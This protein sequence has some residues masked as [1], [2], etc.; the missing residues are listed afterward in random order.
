MKIKLF[1]A[2]VMA[3]MLLSCEGPMGPQ[4]PQGPAGELNW[5]VYDFNIPSSAWE[6]VGDVDGLNSY[7]VYVFEGNQ[8]P[9]ELAQVLEYDGD[10]TGY[11]VSQ[12]DNGDE[13][14][15]PLPYIVYNGSSNS[16]GEWLWSEHIR[17]ISL[18]TVLP[19]MHYIMTLQP[20][21]PHPTANSELV[22]NGKK[23]KIK[24]KN[25]SIPVIHT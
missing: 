17:S 4:G 14:L 9:Q 8:A 18:A 5:K 25:G 16:S 24:N 6:L 23:C 2:A 11:F 7:Y 13:V 21:Q 1:L 12:L 20:L 10:V 22:S 19:F 15:S 3:A